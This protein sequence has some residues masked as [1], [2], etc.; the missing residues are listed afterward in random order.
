VREAFE[1]DLP[2]LDEI[3]QTLL[4]P[5]HIRGGSQPVA[6]AVME[7]HFAGR[8]RKIVGWWLAGLVA[9]AIQYRSMVETL[10]I[11]VTLEL[12]IVIDL[13]GGGALGGMGSHDGSEGLK[14]IGSNVLMKPE[15]T[16]FRLTVLK[17][18]QSNPQSTKSKMAQML[19]PSSEP[20]QMCWRNCWI[21]FVFAEIS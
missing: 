8:L 20:E 12:C 4:Q 6:F 9:N 19:L 3:G 5:D 13:F 16:I 15:K 14:C 11:Q 7:D 17:L 2:A 10:E 18:F 21:S 1:I